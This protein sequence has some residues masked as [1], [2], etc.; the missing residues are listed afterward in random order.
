MT[1]M[2]VPAI[3]SRAPT[4]SAAAIAAPDETPT[5]MPSSRARQGG[6]NA[7]LQAAAVGRRPRYLEAL[8]QLL[9][10]MTFGVSGSSTAVD[11]TCVASDWST[12][13]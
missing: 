10:F 1:R 8:E 3:P 5:G 11:A 4:W 2:R 7:L 6:T 12:L 13:D 9:L